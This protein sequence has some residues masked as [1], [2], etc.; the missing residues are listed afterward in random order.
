M[1]LL[2][3]MAQPTPAREP[4]DIRERPAQQATA[5]GARAQGLVSFTINWGARSGATTN[6]L[7]GHICRRG[8]IRSPLVGS[9]EIGASRSTFEIDASV[10]ARFEKIVRRPDARDPKLRI[11]R[12][13]AGACRR[14]QPRHVA[15][16]GTRPKK[17]IDRTSRKRDR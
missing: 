8:Q 15:R 11:A 7:L 2:L 4:M 9:I 16:A 1:A 12:A 10:A 14:M 13:G 6:R 3:E 5:G 17:L